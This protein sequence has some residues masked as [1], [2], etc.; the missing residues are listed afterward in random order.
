[1][2]YQPLPGPLSFSMAA[3]YENTPPAF[4]S[5]W[6]M[7]GV[8]TIRLTVNGQV[9]KKELKVRMDPRVK[10]S[11]KDLQLQHDLSYQCYKDQINCTNEIEYLRLTKNHIGPI[12]QDDDRV[13]NECKTL[14]NDLLGQSNIGEF[15][16]L[17]TINSELSAL[18]ATLQSA[19]VAPGSQCIL[20]VE[21]AHQ[22]LMY[23]L[24]KFKDFINSRRFW[25]G[26]PLGTQSH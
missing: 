25:R 17:T 7:P 18:E 9:Y 19:D 21:Q 16:S 12:N 6:V 1:M 22:Q 26:E 8:Y 14:I 23:D 4:T 3:V 10:T 20:S 11:R 13:M 24:K 5:P 15:K 2:H